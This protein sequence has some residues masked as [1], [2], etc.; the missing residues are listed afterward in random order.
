MSLLCAASK[1]LSARLLRVFAFSILT[2]AA[3]TGCS[4][5][6][7]VAKKEFV[8]SGDKLMAQKKYAE[9]VIQYRNAVAADARFGEAR[10]K[11]AKAA[12][13]V[14]D[15]TT[16]YREYIRAADLLTNDEAVQL[17]T[18][19][20]LLQTGQWAESKARAER[21]LEINPKNASA[22][23]LLGNALAG[24]K[25]YSGAI[26]EVEQ[27]I[28]SDPK[29]T[30]AY[31]NLGV[32]QLAKGDTVAAEAAFKRA[33]E[34]QPASVDAKLSLANFYWAA[35]RLSDAEV[36]FKQVLLLDSK[37]PD[38]L[39]GL[40]TMYLSAG[41]NADAE[42]AI[43]K[44]AGLSTDVGPQMILAD[45]YLSTGRTEQA[46]SLYEEISKRPE[47]YVR[48]TTRLAAVAFIKNDR[49][50]ASELLDKALTKAPTDAVGRLL[51]AKFLLA[52]GKGAEALAVTS[53]LVKANPNN[54]EAVFHNALAM[55]ATGNI[56]GAIDAL[57]GLSRALPSEFPVQ[58]RLGELYLSRGDAKTAADILGKAV[59]LRPASGVAHLLLAQSLLAEGNLLR[60]EAELRDVE[61]ANPRSPQVAL[62]FGKLYSQQR[63]VS[64]ARAAFE[65]VLAAVPNSVDALDGLLRLDL[66]AKNRAAAIARLE[67]AL[68]KS[69]DNVDLLNLAGATFTAIGEYQRAENVLGR[70][71]AST[72]SNFETFR[73]L[74]NLFVRQGRLDQAKR[75]FGDLAARRPESSAGAETMLGI[76]A[77]LQD[78]PDEAIRAYKSALEHDPQAAV[79]A[80]NLAWLYAKRSSNLEVA[81]QLAQTAKAQLPN[82]ADTSD[83]LGWVY[84]KKGLTPSAIT[85]LREGL[86]Q[87]K[88]SPALHYHLGLAYAQNGDKQEARESL[89]EALRLD[90]HFADAEDAKR[91]LASLKG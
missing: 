11:L 7:E 16:A 30:Y 84:Y 70:A 25:D 77:D 6:P 59:K 29:R 62:L 9:A 34:L 35:N 78:K 57:E 12:E 22:L 19:Q 75:Q 39:R 81:L 54:Q 8:A 74:A 43:K 10:Y 89:E 26:S 51:K 76:I 48:A 14:G 91:V 18:A 23:M 86:S 24:L 73:Q 33:V 83:T 2:V 56:T 42:E 32:I 67:S 41:R 49:L 44:V 69:Q 13:A 17:K 72:T 21:A 36:V 68:A 45:F 60:A 50:H 88:K 80:N 53:Q 28:E 40:A 31:A 3:V 37:S 71:A 47:S 38:A 55:Q 65:R 1:T 58:L 4:K 64:R 46:V 79:A 82:V 61:K 20:V 52:E 87:D 66:A 15:A 85:A 63:D 27:A 90:P 5:D